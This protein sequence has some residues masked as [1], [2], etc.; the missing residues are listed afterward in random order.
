VL[1]GIASKLGL[2]PVLP[3]A[4]GQDLQPQALEPP[5]L[6]RPHQRDTA[7]GPDVLAGLLLERDPT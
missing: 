4:T 7:P 5:Q 1:P 6:Q 3:S 2:V